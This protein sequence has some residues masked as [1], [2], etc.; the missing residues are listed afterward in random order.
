M[1]KARQRK[2]SAFSYG[3]ELFYQRESRK[4]A[5][6]LIKPKFKSVVNAGWR[7]AE[8]GHLSGKAKK[9]VAKYAKFLAGQKLKV[10]RE[11]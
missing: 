1:S 11:N 7:D 10:K 8:V 9:R 3:R 2:E 6:S 4:E 5:L